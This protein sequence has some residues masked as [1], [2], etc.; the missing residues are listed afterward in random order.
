MHSFACTALSRDVSS[1]CVA[2]K[3]Q[4]MISA[5]GASYSYAE[6]VFVKCMS[7][8]VLNVNRKPKKEISAVARRRNLPMRSRLLSLLC[9]ASCRKNKG[10][11]VPASLRV[12][13]T[14][15]ICTRMANDG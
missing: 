14:C 4:A 5:Y 7:W 1:M 11:R 15:S 9:A 13:F 6:L 12:T 3:K 8:N 2:D 10:T